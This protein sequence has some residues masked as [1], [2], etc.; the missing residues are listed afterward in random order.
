MNDK[1]QARTPEPLP[2]WLRTWFFTPAVM[3]VGGSVMTY[4]D[5]L[6]GIVLVMAGVT[7]FMLLFHVVSHLREIGR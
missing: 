2:T 7:M 1:A 3:V 4:H 5:V 6:A